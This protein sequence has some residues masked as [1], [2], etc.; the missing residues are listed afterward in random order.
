M[1][2]AFI[3]ALFAAMF[4]MVSCDKMDEVVDLLTG[5]ATVSL[6]NGTNYQFKSSVANYLGESKVGIIGF[7]ANINLTEDQKLPFPYMTFRTNGSNTGSYAMKS[8]LT[9]DPNTWTMLLNFD[10]STFVNDATSDG[11]VVLIAAGKD[12]WYMSNGGTMSLTAIDQLT[13]DGTFDGVEMRLLTK[14]NLAVL[15]TG[16]L[17]GVVWGD[18]NEMFPVVNMTGSFHSVKM[19]CSALMGQVSSGE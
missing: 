15:Q 2:K 6:D 5:D 19:D 13:I 10:P 16:G 3:L 9:E 12:E 8:F 7:G 17:T 18:I 14:E 1:K 11:S 4:A